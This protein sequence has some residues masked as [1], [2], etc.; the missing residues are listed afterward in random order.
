[1]YAN[2]TTVVPLGNA[3]RAHQHS[4]LQADDLFVQNFL[5]LFQL[6]V[7]Q[8]RMPNFVCLSQCYWLD[9]LI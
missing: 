4:Q 7:Q 2:G 5:V 3:R 1:M 9:Q 6:D 8:S